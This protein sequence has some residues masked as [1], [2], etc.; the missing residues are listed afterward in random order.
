MFTKI[1]DLGF[2]PWLS[3]QPARFDTAAAGVKPWEVT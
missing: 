1:V 2:G 3:H